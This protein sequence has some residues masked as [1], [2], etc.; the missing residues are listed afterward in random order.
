MLL[1]ADAYIQACKHF[2]VSSGD[3]KSYDASTD[4]IHVSYVFLYETF[5]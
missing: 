5:R 4:S 3:N 2:Y 1:N